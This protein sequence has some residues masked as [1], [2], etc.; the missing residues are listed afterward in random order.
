MTLGKKGGIVALQSIRDKSIEE[1]LENVLGLAAVASQAE[2]KSVMAVIAKCTIDL[3][4]NLAETS[5]QIQ[6]FNSSTT[7]LT[8]QV[9]RLNRVLTWATIVIA[10]ATLAAAVTAIIT[11]LKS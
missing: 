11:A 8:K 1:I 3:G 7:A 2:V 9:I 10:A 5:K 6:E 4:E